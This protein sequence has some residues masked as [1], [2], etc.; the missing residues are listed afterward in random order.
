MIFTGLLNPYR[1]RRRFPRANEWYAIF[2][3]WLLGLLASP[4]SLTATRS[5]RKQ[6]VR[7]L[8]VWGPVI[9]SLLGLYRS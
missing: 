2:L 1:A 9:D 8:V 6:M 7:D 3:V 4:Y 5:S